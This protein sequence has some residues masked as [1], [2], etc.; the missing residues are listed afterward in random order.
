MDAND[1]PGSTILFMYGFYTCNTEHWLSFT[2]LPEEVVFL[3][4]NRQLWLD[5]RAMLHDKKAHHKLRP[6]IG[7]QAL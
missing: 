3:T 7:T 4:Q 6:L 5:E 1:V 2:N